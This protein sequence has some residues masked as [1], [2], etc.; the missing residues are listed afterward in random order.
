[1]AR[2]QRRIDPRVAKDLTATVKDPT[3][4]AK[5]PTT[6][7]RDPRPQDLTTTDRDRIAISSLRRAV[8]KGPILLVQSLITHPFPR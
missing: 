3:A 8:H 7:D 4:M 5:D 6:T 1:M 2:G